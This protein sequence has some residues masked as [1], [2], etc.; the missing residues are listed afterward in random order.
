M[1]KSIK[2]EFNEAKKL[3]SINEFVA[4]IPAFELSLPAFRNIITV[5]LNED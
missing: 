1:R 3:A 5:I 2:N 4:L